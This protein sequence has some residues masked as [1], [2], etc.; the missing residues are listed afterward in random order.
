MAIPA[1]CLCGKLL[2]PETQALVCIYQI[3]PHRRY[4]SVLIAAEFCF[5]MGKE[6][7]CRSQGGRECIGINLERDL[8]VP[9]GAGESVS[10]V[11]DC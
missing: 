10:T 11:D 2:L 7:A 4:S 3:E 6:G 5:S 9:L 8:S 1:Y